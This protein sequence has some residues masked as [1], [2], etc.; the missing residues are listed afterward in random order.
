[1]VNE[2]IKLFSGYSGDFGIADMS[3]ATLDSEKK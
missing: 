2:F 1:M 3:K